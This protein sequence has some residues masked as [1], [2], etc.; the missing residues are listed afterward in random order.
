MLVLLL[1]LAPAAAGAA[2]LTG[3]AQAD[4]VR[5]EESSDQLDPATGGPRNLDRFLVRRARLR[6]E[7]ERRF[8]AFIGELDFNTVAGPQVGPRQLELAALLP[9][10]LA[11][12]PAGAPP[13]L[14]L[15]AGLFR[16]PFGHEIAEEPDARRIFA[17][18]TL[19]SQALFPGEYDLGV[20]LAGELSWLALTVA[21][22]N[23]EP[24]GTRAFPGRDPNAAKD[25]LARAVARAELGARIR[26]E[27]GASTMLGS[28][29][30]Q[31]TLATK[32]TLVW[33]DRNEDGIAQQSELLLIRGA[34]ATPS[35]NFERFGLAG[36]LRVL[37]A[38]PPGELRV[39]AE[40]V[41]AKNLDRAVRPADPVLL[42]IDQRAFGAHLSVTQEL[43]RHAVIGVR[44]ERYEPELD[45]SQLESG[46]LARTEERFQAISVAAGLLHEEEGIRGA[47]LVDATHRSD[48]LGRDAAGLPADLANDSL[49]VR[50]Q[51]A[52]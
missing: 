43:T 49:T 10:E 6:V 12:L 51:L 40:V 48:P 3:Y 38:L 39:A 15:G 2:E 29:F 47:L 8:A 50:L 25:L 1:L 36:E 13:P 44:V 14:R 20:Y 30:H 4:Y 31:G 16:A 35:E 17:E 28:G 34:A 5:S 41:T 42:G 23:G 26:L 45:S 37:A 52:F 21:A 24:L 9:P 19:I 32:D 22:Q 33:R 27:A 46:Q 18:R 11:G 7:E